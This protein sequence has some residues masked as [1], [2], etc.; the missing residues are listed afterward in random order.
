MQA[1]LRV[2][3]IHDLSGF[4][5]TSLLTV[6][7]ILYRMGIE[8]AALP[9]ALLS[10]NTDYPNYHMQDNYLQMKAHL[11]HWAA[12]NMRFDALYSGF[13]GSP[14]QIAMLLNY[15]P[16]MK[17][18]QAPILVDPVMADAGKLYSCYDA[19]MVVAMRS[20]VGIADIITPNFTEAALLLGY[21]YPENPAEVNLQDW[22][23]ELA[24]LGPRHVVIT[25]APLQPDTSAFVVYYERESKLFESFSC[26]RI[27]VSYPGTGDCFASLVLG[28]LLN[29]FSE[30]ESVAGAVDYL[31]YAIKLSLPLVSEP[32]DGI[33]LAAALATQ[34]LT[35]YF[36]R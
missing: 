17:K 19:E 11:E 31:H 2:L 18:P 13:L 28:G 4:G 26:S 6:I 8:V 33:A 25:S 35:Y 9:T 20:L 12:M 36:K 1:A 10:T 7:P 34:P 14:K 21:P 24:K 30:A 5:H 3:A 29:G 27:P 15:L 16:E 22:C 32:R 23:F